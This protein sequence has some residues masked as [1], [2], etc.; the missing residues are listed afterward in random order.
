MRKDIFYLVPLSPSV[1]NMAI[2]V[3][4][5]YNMNYVTQGIVNACALLL[6]DLG[7]VNPHIISTGWSERI[8]ASKLEL[9]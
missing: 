8:T 3:K 7:A 2:V 1:N 4:Q 9:R 6:T 5:K